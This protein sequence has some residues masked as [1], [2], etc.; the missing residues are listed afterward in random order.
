MKYSAPYSSKFSVLKFG[1]ATVAAIAAVALAAT[2]SVSQAA[3]GRGG[4]GGGAPRAAA[5]P[6]VG[7]GGGGGGFHG[8]GGG[9][10]FRGAAVGGG[11]FRGGGGGGAAHFAAR[12]QISRPQF[13][14]RPQISRPQFSRSQVARPQFSRSAAGRSFAGPNV[15][16]GRGTV[17]GNRSFARGNA[18]V[19]SR[20]G[21]ATTRGAS[22]FNAA[23]ISQRN[24]LRNNGLRNNG[25]GNNVAA[26]ARGARNTN[27]RTARNANAIRSALVS[28]PVN[29]ALRTT[30]GLRN[31]AA[32]A[33]VTASL[34][35]A[36]FHHGRGAWN[37]WWRHRN[38]GYGW[39]GPV[40][41]P[42]AY[43]DVYN[44]A[45]WGDD[46]DPSFWGYGYSD[47]YAGMFAPYGYDDLSGY[48]EYLPQGAPA[49]TGSSTQ[50]VGSTGSVSPGRT[51]NGAAP[52]NGTNLAQMCG[53][54][55]RDIAGLPIEEFDKAIGPGDAQ[56][57]ALE[58]L[59]NASVKAAQIIRSAC[60]ADIA[61]TAP[62]RLAAMQQRIEAM[63]S[64]VQTVQPPLEKFYAALSDEQKARVAALSTP[65]SASRNGETTGSVS[66]QRPAN[67]GPNATN[68]AAQDT[69]DDT[70]QDTNASTS[71]IARART[72]DV[73]QP[74][75]T[76]WP[77]ETI[78]RS[79]RPN[80]E[81]RKNLDALRNAA[82]QAADTLKASCE[83]RDALTPPA[84]LAAV[85]QRLD[86]MLQAVKIVRPAMDTL[87]WLAQR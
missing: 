1:T 8:G 63:V 54:D 67:T 49:R 72:C 35:T 75:V 52:A 34:A 55:N 33:L 87:L 29:Q 85:G 86:A 57:A 65:Q 40:F 62:N 6:H 25:V 42:F 16:A 3:P 20:V 60:P 66:S 36:A 4:G 31:P 19:R 69:K 53:E 24:G 82:A 51:A 80:D 74:G 21:A 71:G 11:G 79:V 59:A 7:G 18:V 64:A 2:L 12:P 61:L 58:D 41:W 70:K 30:A 15:S 23:G 14:A 38:G 39:V 9:G 13:S 50:T 44:Y 77:S 5:A 56:H 81:Q 32:R 26:T 27:L 45:F 73:A 78:E 68:S 10:G 48:A 46:Y 84:R 17:R 43:Y 22:R 28:R 76:A 47:L 37:G 83:P